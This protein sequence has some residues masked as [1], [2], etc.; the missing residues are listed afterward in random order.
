MKIKIGDYLI[1]RLNELKI[2]EIFG[3]PGDYNLGFL[4]LIS[5][6]KEVKW[7]GNCNELN[8]A[9]AAD[10]YARIKGMGAVVTTFG[11][12]ALSAINGIAGSFTENV[13]VIKIA[14]SPSAN[15]QLNR[16]LVHHSTGEGE[17]DTFN[18]M[19]KEITV[20][21]AVLSEL[22]AASEIDRVL[23]TVYKEKRPGY[24][25]LP[26]D[27]VSKEIEVEMQPLDLTMK[28]NEKTLKQFIND[29]KS[30]VAESKNQFILADYKVLRTNTEKELEAFI[31]MAKVPAST[32]SM[33][34]S[35]IDENN[36]YFVGTYT[37]N[38]SPKA[39]KE[40]IINSDLA[41]LIG[42][43]L[44]DSTTAGFSFLNPSIKTI[45]IDLHHARIGNKIYTDVLLKDAIEA[46]TNSKIKFSNSYKVE[47]FEVES[48][49]AT[50]DNLTQNR[51][52]KQLQHFIKENDV[53]VAEQ[54]TS[55]FGASTMKMPS[56]A[57]FIGQ[58]LW[59]S[60]GYTVPSVLGTHMADVS[61][62]NILLVG[63]GS[64]QLTAQEISTM[65]RHNL[66]TIVFV[67]NNDGY[68][69][70]R[71]IHGATKE[72]NHI[73]MWDYHKLPEIFAPNA[74][75]APMTFSVKTE[76][77]LANALN[78]IN[79]NQNKFAFVEV[80][81]DKNDVPTILGDLA[82]LFIKQNGY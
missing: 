51:Y 20:A 47:N 56:G 30:L 73:Q 46:L 58:P 43:K 79:T 70:E 31:N 62:R 42:V 35:A 55:Y 59:G 82:Q 72:Y 11:V 41:L 37:G 57:K 44:T 7:I 4:D 2:E 38:L 61:K 64:F 39:V 65:L 34:K 67:V 33:G 3:V 68:T 23:T 60:I 1:K 10:G 6:S 27:L 45:E 49:E 28:S 74:K 78:E 16:T 50:D 18:R 36:K 8:A 22:N 5:D 80:H 71:V 48:F 13:P 24:I 69:V 14:G 32:L 15:I 54:G 25:E 63:D 75:T 12:G 29:V 76:K 26:V 66:N 21:Q 52:F 40:A 81:M 77:E 19:Y 53:I 17:F 9:Y